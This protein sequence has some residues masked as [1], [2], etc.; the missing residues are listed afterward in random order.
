MKFTAKRMLAAGA[1][2]VAAVVTPISLSVVLPGISGT[3]ASSATTGTPASPDK[4]IY[5]Q[6]TGTPATFFQYVPGTGPAPL[7]QTVTAGGPP[8]GTPTVSGAILNL[9]GKVYAP[10]PNSDYYL[11]PST[12]AAVGTHQ[13]QTGVCPIM[14][15]STIDNKTGKGAE[16]LD[17]SPGTNTV[18][19]TNRLFSDAQIPIQR[20]HSGEGE[21]DREGGSDGDGDSDDAPPAVT[22]HLVE[23]DA[24]GTQLAMQ[25]CTI[26]GPEGTTITADSNGPGIGGTC[27]GAT[28][29]EF[30]SVEV[31]DL[32]PNTS[33]SVVG[34]A[35]TFTLASQLCAGDTPIEPTA[36]PA[37][38]TAP[39]SVT[40][41]CKNYS[42]YT[43]GIDPATGDQQLNFNAFSSNPVPFTF[44]VTW[45][46]V[47][48]ACQP[49]EQ[50]VDAG[51]TPFPGSPAQLSPCH[52][53]VFSFDGTT[54]YDTNF[55]VTPSA[56]EPV[57]VTSDKYTLTPAGTVIT[58]TWS[59]LADLWG[60]GGH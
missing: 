53:S 1:L 52:L 10:T 25:T 29:A 55:C 40:Q 48:P 19:G 54:Y 36:A 21:G 45:A 50:P 30:E 2:G 20:K 3:P 38:V 11:N 28:A 59:A 31:Q 9:G 58:E 46:P 34:P 47:E 15:S 32:T 41:G 39:L 27:T 43:Y 13:L 5:G 8:C 16:A 23:Y 44:T 4:I 12:S 33:V 17:F 51:A 56:N 6:T 26:N 57:C 49:V 24:S 18:I 37:G 35:A 14:P 60:R 42:S 7:P 22:V